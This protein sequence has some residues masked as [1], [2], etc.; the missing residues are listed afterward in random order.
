MTGEPATTAAWDE[1]Q[2]ERLRAA[3]FAEFDLPA[4]IHPGPEAEVAMNGERPVRSSSRDRGD[5]PPLRDEPESGPAP[6]DEIVPRKR[7]PLAV[8]AVRDLLETPPPKPPEL[9]PGLARVGEIIGLAGPRSFAKSWWWANLAYLADRGEGSFLGTFG[10]RERTNTLLCHGEGADWAGVDR[11]LRMG[12]YGRDCGVLECRDRW[13]IRV[14]KRRVAQLVRDEHGSE[15]I[16]DEFPTAILDERLEELIVEYGIGLCVIDPWAVYYSG[17]ENDNDAVEA[18]IDTVRDLA[19]RRQV[20]FGI[21]HH[22]TGK[23]DYRE[24]EDAWRGATRLADSVDVRITLLPHYTEQQ[25]RKQ[26]MTRQQA[27][28]YV[29][30]RFLVRNGPPVDD[31]SIVFDATNGWWSRWATPGGEGVGAKVALEAQDVADRLAAD[32][33]R[34]P[35]VAKA[36]A[37]LGLA[38]ATTRRLLA[39]AHR[40]GLVEEYEGPRGAKGTCLP[41]MGQPEGGAE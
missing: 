16:T 38:E 27:R 5:E 10:I 18:A 25:W 13:R 33:G 29:D 39:E 17:P 32:G 12:A 36:A 23:A 30:V 4:S 41:G 34:W 15:T 26:G 8:V 20:A 3:P 35:S 14:T 37:A 1:Q 28:R 31:F 7:H 24:P 22:T 21:P 2:R 40:A 9:V 6:D 19:R 11:W